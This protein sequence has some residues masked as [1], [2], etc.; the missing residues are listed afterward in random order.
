MAWDVFLDGNIKSYE[1]NK[2]DLFETIK[3]IRTIVLYTEDLTNFLFSC[4]KQ[5]KTSI[6]HKLEL[7]EHSYKCKKGFFI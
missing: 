2:L 3:Q 5:N 7:V 4:F 6:E 1:Q